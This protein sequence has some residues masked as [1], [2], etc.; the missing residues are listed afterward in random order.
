MPSDGL[1]LIYDDIAYGKSLGTTSKFPKDAMAFKWADELATTT[2]KY[3]E[4]SPSRTGLI[5]P[6]AVFETVQLEGTS[7]S[8]ASVHN[9]SVM[10]ELKLGEGDQISVYKAN[11]IIPQIAE[12][13]TKSASIM[14]PEKCPACDGITKVEVLNEAKVLYCTNP[15]CPAKKNKRFALFVSRNALNIDGLSEATLEKLIAKGFLHSLTDIFALEQHKDEISEMEGFGTKSAENLISAI[16]VAKNTT[17]AK[18]VYGLGIANIGV[19]NAKLIARHYAN[20]A[21][22]LKM[23]T[24]EELLSIDSIGEVIADAFVSYFEVEEN[25]AEFD[26]LCELLSF[27]KTNMN[28]NQTLEGKT[29]VITGSLNHYKDRSEMK[30]V[31]ESLGGKVTGSVSK[32]TDYLINNDSESMS[33]KNKKAKELDIPI[34][35]E[36]NFKE[37]FIE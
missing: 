26:V 28:K 16:D 18:L 29:I 30:E 33:S 37:Q 1:V 15:N 7:V 27:E 13:L 22:R 8:R 23:A 35:T 36:E 12:N 25:K 19:A 9:L 24:K 5:N 2:L 14:P 17:M 21:D 4:W 34:L 10:E 20:D 32:K 31:I 3:I 6:V 11:M